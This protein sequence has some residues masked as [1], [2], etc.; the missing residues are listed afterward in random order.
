MKPLTPAPL[1]LEE[2]G[3]TTG[4]CTSRK[5]HDGT[6]DSRENR[7][8]DHRIW[9]EQRQACRALQ[10]ALDDG[11]AMAAWTAPQRRRAEGAVRGGGAIAAGA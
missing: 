10:H 8:T 9:S 5:H 7:K 1:V 4:S 6:V 11:L 3:D 2:L